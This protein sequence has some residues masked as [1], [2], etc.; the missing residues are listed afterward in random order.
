MHPDNGHEIAAAIAAAKG[1][2]ER[3]KA[4]EATAKATVAEAEARAS[5]AQKEAAKL[6]RAAK[7]DGYTVV[8]KGGKPASD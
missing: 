7:A 8:G 3:F 4:A 1:E 5:A 6:E 2:A